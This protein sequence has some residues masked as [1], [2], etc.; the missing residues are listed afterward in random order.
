MT[1]DVIKTFPGVYDAMLGQV[2]ARMSLQQ[3]KAIAMQT[4]GCV[5]LA[6]HEIGP[7]EPMHDMS[8]LAHD[9]LAMQMGPSMTC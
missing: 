3:I 7:G 8:H 9:A 4:L 2:C 5:D 6:M 1:C